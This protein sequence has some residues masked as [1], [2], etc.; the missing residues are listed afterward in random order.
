MPETN[1][2]EFHQLLG[3][4]LLALAFG[5]LLLPF[6]VFAIGLPFFRRV[7][8]FQQGEDG[9]STVEL[10]P[11]KPGALSELGKYLAAEKKQ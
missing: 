6:A 9:A 2:P 7:R 1:T 8:R 3:A 10:G 4:M 5:F 11:R